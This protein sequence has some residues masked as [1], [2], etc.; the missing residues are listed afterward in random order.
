MIGSIHLKCKCN[1]KKVPAVYS[2]IG[3]K[4]FKIRKKSHTGY[5]GIL[6][7][8]RLFMMKKCLD[9]TNLK[10]IFVTGK[11]ALDICHNISIIH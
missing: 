7:V 3:S 2:I 4:L 5:L 8:Y 11:G 6:F 1:K 9:M 10:N